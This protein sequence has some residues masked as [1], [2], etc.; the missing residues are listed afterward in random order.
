[1]ANKPAIGDDNSINTFDGK[2][3]QIHGQVNAVGTGKEKAFASQTIAPQIPFS[4]CIPGP[5]S[6]RRRFNAAAT[7]YKPCKVIKDNT[8]N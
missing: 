8:N 4:K 6:L 7:D 1:M 3:D 5:L 2:T